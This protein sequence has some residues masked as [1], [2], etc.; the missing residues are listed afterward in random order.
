MQGQEAPTCVETWAWWAWV[1][2][3]GSLHCTQGME[4]IGPQLEQ[5]GW[6]PPFFNFP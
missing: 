2:K 4:V 5:W 1:D 6:A 3:P